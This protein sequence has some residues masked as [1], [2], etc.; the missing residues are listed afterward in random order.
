V[1]WCGV[2]GGGG[3]HRDKVEGVAPVRVQRGAGAKEGVVRIMC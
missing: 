2:L 1:G 3:G